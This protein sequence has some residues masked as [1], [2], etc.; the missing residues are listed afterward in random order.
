LRKKNPE[1]DSI[2][3]TSPILSI[4]GN[5]KYAKLNIIIGGTGTA[6]HSRPTATI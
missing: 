4:P 2:T 6:F 5:A 1:H 3:E